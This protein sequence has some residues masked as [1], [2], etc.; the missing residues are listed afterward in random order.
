MALRY[1]RRILSVMLC[2]AMLAPHA[3]EAQRVQRAA[4]APPH[5][6][7]TSSVMGPERP[8]RVPYILGGAITGG[9]VTGILIY[10]ELKNSDAIL[11]E[12]TGVLVTLGGTLVGALLGWVVY[13]IRH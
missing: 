13:E 8:S 12:I 4:F 5:D 7:L 10:R 9:V 6:T 11:G 2:A 1:L 3:M